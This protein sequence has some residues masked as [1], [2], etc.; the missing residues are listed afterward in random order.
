MI[1]PGATFVNWLPAQPNAKSRPF[2]TFSHT[3]H[4]S[5]IGDAGCQTCH[6][7][8]P[9]SEYAKFFS[10]ASGSDTA[11][12]GV[13]FQSNFAPISRM[14]C[15]ECHQPRVAG[16]ACILCHRYHAAPVAGDLAEVGRFRTSLGG[17][18]TPAE[19]RRSQNAK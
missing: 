17:K 14:Q 19:E 5:L 3:T 10:S 18:F 16:D 12:E 13:T 11:H 7:L 4:F 2:T 15:A 8:N 6:V 1:R 9:K